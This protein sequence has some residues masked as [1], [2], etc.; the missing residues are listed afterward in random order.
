MT[1][2]I[3]KSLRG[4]RRVLLGWLLGLACYATIYSSF[5]GRFDEI[6]AAKFDAMPEAMRTAFGWSSG[7]STGAGYLDAVI[8]S[9]IGP[10]LLIVFAIVL[11]NRGIARPEDGGQLDF[12]LANP[13]SRNRFLTGRYLI[14]AGGILAGAAVIL[15]A[16]LSF[17]VTMDMGIGI[18]NII[19]A[20]SGMAL[21]ALVFGTLAFAVGAATGRP[22]TVLGTAGAVVVAAYMC[23]VLSDLIDELS[24]LRWLSPFHYYTANQPLLHGLHPGHTLV[25]VA[26]VTGLLAVSF[27]TFNRRD[28]GV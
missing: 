9:M 25:L 20:T 27:V 5:Y 1:S 4:Q 16:V 8:Y 12:Y 15:I 3:R 28:V 7:F 22:G 2:L 6:A 24:W 21:V 11:G 19:A 23:K 17:A 14:L 18:A 26:L 13:I 10:L